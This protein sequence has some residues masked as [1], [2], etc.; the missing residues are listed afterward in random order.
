MSEE[1]KTESMSFFGKCYHYG[2]YYI[3]WALGIADPKAL[4][5]YTWKYKKIMFHN[6]SDYER[7]INENEGYK[8]AGTKDVEITYRPKISVIVPVYNVLDKYLIA[9]IKSVLK[10]SYD[11]FE[12]CLADDCSTY[13]N[14]KK[15]L[16]KFEKNPKVK[17]VYREKNGNISEATNSA[18]SVATGDFIALL[19]CDDILAKDALLTVVETLN[20][21]PDLDFIYSDEDKVDE[22]GKHRHTPHFKPDWSP[23]TFMSHMY[24]CHLGV[25][26]KSIA[27]EIGGFRKGFEGA[28][29]YDFTLRFTE[30]TDRIAHIPRILYH[31]V[32]REESTSVNPDAKPYFTNAARKAK[33]EAL[34][35]RGLTATLETL[36][37]NQIRVNYTPVGEPKVSIVIPSKDNPDIL[38]NCIDS[39]LKYT[40]YPNYEIVVVDN[41]SSDENK[42][43]V[44]VLT[45]DSR[46]KYVYDKYDFNFSKMCNIGVKESTGEYI[47]LLNDDTEVTEAGWLTRM[48]GHAM[49][50]HTGAV[51][52][53][54]LYPDKKT[55][56][57]VGVI[58]IDEGPAH[59]FAGFADD[60]VLYFGRNRWDYNYIAVTGACLMVSRKKYEEVGGFDESFAV[61]YNDVDFCLK[62]YEAGYYNVVRNDVVL[63]HHESLSRGHDNMDIE[64]I[65]R[66]NRERD[67][68]YD[69]HPLFGHNDPFYNINFNHHNTD[70]SFNTSSFNSFIE[71]TDSTPENAQL[72]GHLD[73][74]NVSPRM[75]YIAGWIYEKGNKKS[76]DMKQKVLLYNEK[77]SYI[78]DTQKGYRKDVSDAFPEE[79]DL[80]FCGFR[81]E[82]DREGMESGVYH[83]AIICDKG[84][85]NQPEEVVL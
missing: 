78:L 18:L 57:H 81:V 12:L 38:K 46:I 66:L 6:G 23:D 39:I 47:L 71:G 21:N 34:Q 65:K 29:D 53:R 13:P 9:C 73:L 15:T 84:R 67:R 40:E 45:G 63:I 24:T 48:T 50:P 75:L 28:Q 27:D 52:A 16:K 5:K 37:L 11:N 35:R 72:N 31:W 82:A 8:S 1:N 79:G 2:V 36:P 25:F 30:K 22:S 20:E 80:R 77:H 58:M 59:A 69:I 41:G 43:K 14:V 3:K 32:E 62:L 4:R 56:Q 61:T 26:R 74:I 70:F 7:W 54:L 68:M 83:T 19:D 55:I 49:L 60:V 42:K 17:V 33:E 85:M 10:Q 64:K 44:E 51:G 76:N